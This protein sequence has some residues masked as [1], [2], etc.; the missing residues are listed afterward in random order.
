MTASPAPL[1]W[2]VVWAPA[3][4]AF[5]VFIIGWM[6]FTVARRQAAIAKRKLA[7]ELYEKRRPIYD[8]CVEMVLAAARLGAPADLSDSYRQAKSH[9]GFLFTPQVTDVV[10]GVEQAAIGI[11]KRRLSVEKTGDLKMGAAFIIESGMWKGHAVQDL[12]STFMP[13]LVVEQSALI[14]SRWR[15]LVVYLRTLWLITKWRLQ[16]KNPEWK[17]R[18]RH[19]K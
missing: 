11:I 1:P 2:P 5:G 12:Q 15:R 4:S 19:G 7:M 6:T 10:E 18:K 9:L 13:Y 8:A 3:F 17:L 16:G 14:E